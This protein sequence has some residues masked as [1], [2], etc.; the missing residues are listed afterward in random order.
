MNIAILGATG[1][2]GKRLTSKL[3][4]NEKYKLTLIS[5][6]SGEVFDDSEQITAKSIDAGNLEDLKE[7]LK[8]QDLVYCAISGSDL[9]S[10]AENLV[11]INPKRL[12]LM[13]AVGIYNELAEGNGFEYNVDNEPPQIPNT[14]A[15]N[16]LEGSELDYTI[17]R[18]G[19]LRDG[20]EDDYVITYKGETPKGYYTTFQSVLKIALEIIENPELYLRESISITRDMT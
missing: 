11:E 17:F 20:D 5:K 2:F 14:K 13:G 4:E 8:N 16:I 15:V 9:P 1:K 18:P 7:A 12:I 19:F 6:S 10:I 3:L